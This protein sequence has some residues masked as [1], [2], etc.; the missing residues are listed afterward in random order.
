MS[1]LLRLEY[2]EF[3]VRTGRPNAIDLA[4]PAWMLQERPVIIQQSNRTH[5]TN[6]RGGSYTQ[7]LG[8][9]KVEHRL[10]LIYVPMRAGVSTHW[11]RPLRELERILG[12]EV[13]YYWGN[14]Y[15]GHDWLF[16][17]MQTNFSEM[18]YGPDVGGTNPR[19]GGFF[20]K[21]VE[22]SLMLTNDD[23]TFLPYTPPTL[24]EGPLA[25]VDG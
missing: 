15:F 7:L 1:T 22:V 18:G 10:N 11:Y 16:V 13:T 12:Q 25:E 8:K 23:P 21:W 6:I 4:Y 19:R 20:S 17:D 9:N 2:G 5:T 14:D 3:E 24:N